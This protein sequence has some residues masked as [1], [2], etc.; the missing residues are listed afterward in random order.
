MMSAND[1]FTEL[2]DRLRAGEDAA[3]RKVFG[4]FA[5][6][7]AALARRQFAARLRHKVDPE[8]VV[9]SAY[10]S[11]F[12]RHREGKLEVES[13]DGL[14]GLLTLLTLRKC[15]DRAEY[16]QAGKRDVR[17]EAVAATGSESGD[18]WRQGVDREPT[19]LEAAVLRETVEQ[20]LHDL[21]EH[22][23]PILQLSLQGYTARE[24]SQ[25]LGRAERSVRRLR[26][27]I[28]RKL[29]CLQEE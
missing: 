29:A 4:Q 24:I 19:P 11:F 2:M 25:Q 8:D 28:R 16:F 10:K 13:W 14:W 3:A 6:R 26:E 22:Q 5:G 18:S 15:A 20:L 7:L 12:L 9:Q 1:S 27:Q 21:P 17:R 23:R